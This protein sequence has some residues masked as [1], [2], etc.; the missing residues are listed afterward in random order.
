MTQSEGKNG[1]SNNNFN[2]ID[3]KTSNDSSSLKDGGANMESKTELL[4][5]IAQRRMSN[6][7][8]PSSN[9]FS[10]R[11]F[12]SSQKQRETHI[13]GPGQPPILQNVAYKD[14]L[15]QEDFA[16]RVA[17]S[18]LNDSRGEGNIDASNFDQ[19]SH[20]SQMS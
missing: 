11:G 6:E 10:N 19:F 5:C 17:Y 2:F 4:G 20:T 16:Q 3:S 7:K 14:N 1:G 12:D 8:S 13:Q 15:S 18:N 9:N